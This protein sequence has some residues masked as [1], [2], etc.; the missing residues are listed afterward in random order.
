M[1]KG[2]E[3]CLAVPPSFPLKINGHFHR[4]RPYSCKKILQSKISKTGAS[5]IILWLRR[6]PGPHLRKSRLIGPNP[7]TSSGQAPN[8]QRTRVKGFV[9]FNDYLSY[10][11][12]NSCQY[13]CLPA[14]NYF[15]DSTN[16]LPFFNSSSSASL[17]FN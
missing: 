6:K 13:F 14:I 2:R 5:A 7:S 3:V 11:A 16:C 10:H 12:K 1:H 17:L 9:I 4:L 15:L 8:Q